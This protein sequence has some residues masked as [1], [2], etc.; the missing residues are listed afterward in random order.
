VRHARVGVFLTERK[1]AIFDVIKRA[2]DT[3]ISSIEIIGTLYE[4]PVSPAAIKSHVWQINDLLETTAYIIRSDRRR[5]YLTRR[6][7]RRVA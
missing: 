4:R 2:G 7:V 1:A 6:H 3:G 5:W